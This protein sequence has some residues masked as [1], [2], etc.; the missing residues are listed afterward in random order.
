MRQEARNRSGNTAIVLKWGRVF[1]Q[2]VSSQNV[3]L[4]QLGAAPMKRVNKI[5]IIR[6]AK[7][8]PSRDSYEI[9]LD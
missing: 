9:R 5:D 6:N 4:C 8:D 7:I 2:E 1:D 3:G